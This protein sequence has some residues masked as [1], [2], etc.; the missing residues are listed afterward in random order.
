MS[1]EKVTKYK[2]EK[3]KRKETMKKQKR[4]KIVRDCLFALIPIALVGVIGLTIYTTYLDSVPRP[5][6]DVKYQTI[7]DFSDKMGF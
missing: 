6:V 7:S 3:L 5:S 1:Q 4:D 2:E